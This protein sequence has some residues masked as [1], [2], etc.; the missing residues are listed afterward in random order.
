MITDLHKLPVDADNMEYVCRPPSS[1]PVMPSNPRSGSLATGSK[2]TD[3]RQVP[4]TDLDLHEPSSNESSKRRV[5]RRVSSYLSV[6]EEED[7]DQDIEAS[8]DSNT[9]VVPQGTNTDLKARDPFLYFSSDKRR[10][11]HLLGKDLPSMPQDDPKKL[12]KKTCL[13][14]EMDPFT[15]MTE[16]FP[17]LYDGPLETSDEALD[18]LL[19]EMLDQFR[20]SC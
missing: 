7:R 10:L 8:Y 5:L 1:S 11:E 4:S 3:K 14:F 12:Q 19:D 18:E 9:Q 20:S 17:E 16:S 6:N 15:I 2:T 13:S